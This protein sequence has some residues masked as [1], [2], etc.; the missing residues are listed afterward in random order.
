MEHPA[1]HAR[2]CDRFRRVEHEIRHAPERFNITHLQGRD[3]FEVEPP[4]LQNCGIGGFGCVWHGRLLRMV[5]Q[6]EN[7]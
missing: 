4:I 6:I 1:V 7:G 3:G 2:P 5:H